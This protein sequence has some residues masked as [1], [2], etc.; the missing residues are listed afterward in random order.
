[1]RPEL[2]D[3]QHDANNRLRLGYTQKKRRQ[4]LIAPTGAGKSVCAHDL[5]AN[6]MRK[7]RRVWFLVNRVQLVKQFSERLTDAG[8]EHGI[9]RGEESEKL[10]HKTIVGSVQT[11][12][13]RELEHAPDVI[14]IDECHWVPG[15]KQYRSLISKY[16]DATILGLTATPWAKGMA[17]MAE[18]V[19]GALFENAVVAASYSQLIASGHLVPFNHVWAPELPDLRG[20]KTVNNA[21]GETDYQDK[22]VSE[23]MNQPKLVGDIVAHWMRLAR[24][25]KTVVFACDIKHS[26][27]IVQAFRNAGVAAEHLD[28]YCEHDERAAAMARVRS[29]E[30]M[31]ISCA[32]LLAEG[33]DEPSVTTII[34]A[35]PTRSRIRFIQM[36]GRVMRPYPGKDGATLIDHT[37]TVLKLGFPDSDQDYTLDGAKPRAGTAPKEKEPRR[38]VKCGY[39]DHYKHLAD[40]PACPACGHVAQKKPREI[41]AAEG[42]LRQ[43]K[44]KVNATMAEKQ[45]FF[46][47]LLGYAQQ[48][49]LSH[50][51]ASN[52]YRHKFGVWPNSL[53]RIPAEPSIYTMGFVRHRN[54]AYAKSQQRKR[55]MAQHEG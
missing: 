46:S 37:G 33:W 23:V 29:G 44:R 48:R 17:R 50:G 47:E 13:R 27:A 4:V 38:C 30:T 31:V 42:E 5:V 32:A 52:T 11:A 40:D 7:G 20:V 49:G 18:E 36:C 3:Y 1:M 10:W 39:V 24:D 9:L 16:K 35:R 28:C 26:M 25:T 6:A 14:V 21:L 41:V 12:A 45:Q 55:E 2:R 19:G 54:I 15:S 51:W 53:N 43:V 8:I 22:A 34:L